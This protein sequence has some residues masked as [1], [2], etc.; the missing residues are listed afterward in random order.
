ML[1][2]RAVRH[3]DRPI[4]HFGFRNV[5]P[6]H[7]RR[8]ISRPRSTH[9]HVPSVAELEIIGPVIH[10]NHWKAYRRI[11]GA[12]GPSYIP[13][14]GNHIS[15]RPHPNSLT[16]V[17]PSVCIYTAAII[18]VV[19][20]VGIAPLGGSCYAHLEG[21]GLMGQDTHAHRLL[22]TLL[23]RW[24]CLGATFANHFANQFPTIGHNVTIRLGRIHVINQY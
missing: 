18:A 19:S 14:I 11:I 1:Y 13:I 22:G 24:K 16:I 7:S 9:N 12:A 20:Q 2:R 8:I 17:I 3:T 10:S 15:P 5:I 4:C 21:F 6:A 23:G